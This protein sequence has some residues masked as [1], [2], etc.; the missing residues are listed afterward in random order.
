MTIMKCDRCGDAVKRGMPYKVEVAVLSIGGGAY[1]PKSFDLCDR[2]RE[3]L[4][5][6]IRKGVK[7]DQV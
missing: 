1:F 3:D 6:W 4:V 5:T 2:C 7:D